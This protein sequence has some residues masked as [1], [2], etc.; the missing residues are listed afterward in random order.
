MTR[1]E[2]QQ[3]TRNSLLNA[4]GKLFCHNGL[5]G[6]SVD[7]VAQAAGYTKGAFYANF[8]SK[9][10]LFLVM[11]DERFARELERIDRA[12]K[13][14]AEPHAEAQDAAAEFIHFAGDEDW[15]RLYF[16]FVAHAARDDEF[17]QEL[18]TRQ[19]AMR[20]K[21]VDT[22]TRWKAGYGKQPP[23]PLADIT[24]MVYCMADGFLVDRMIEPGLREDLYTTMIAVFLRGLEAIASEEPTGA[25]A[26]E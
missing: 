17:R 26:A 8:K 25:P 13:G 18:A 23:L 21:L 12:L 3:R 7:Q 20:E 5:E 22:F 14:A 6:A 16:Q 10:E 2:K 9:E 15:P 19:Q 1:R 4:A 11:L 24:A